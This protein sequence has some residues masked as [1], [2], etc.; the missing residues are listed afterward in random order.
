MP[1]E[2]LTLSDCPLLGDAPDLIE[3]FNAVARALQMAQQNLP[4]LL[5]ASPNLV[6]EGRRLR[7]RMVRPRYQV[8]CLGTNQSDKSLALNNVLDAKVVPEGPGAAR[9][10]TVTRLQSSQP[11]TAPALVLRFSSQERYHY[12][13]NELARRVGLLEPENLTEDELLHELQARAEDRPQAWESPAHSEDL[14]TL[15][16]LVRSAQAFGASVFREPPFEDASTSFTGRADFL[17]PNHNDTALNKYTLVEEVVVRYPTQAIPAELDMI[18]LPGPG[19]R[20]SLDSLVAN[21]LLPQCDGVLVFLTPATVMDG[22]ADALFAEL[23]QG[24][25][26]KQVGNVWL[27]VTNFDGLPRSQ[28]FGDEHGETLFDALAE[29]RQRHQL[30]PG[31]LVLLSNVL[32]ATGARLTHEGRTRLDPSKVFPRIG[33]APDDPIPPR[34]SQYR[35]IGRAFQDLVRDGGIGRL[36]SVIGT[37]L[38]AALAAELRRDVR[39]QIGALGRELHR[40]VDSQQKL[41]TH[42]APLRPLIEECQRCVHQ[43]LTQLKG[44][45]DFIDTWARQL[46]NRLRAHFEQDFPTTARNDELTIDRVAQLFPQHALSLQNCLQKVFKHRI[47]PGLYEHI[48]DTLPK[49]DIPLDG[50]TSPSLAWRGY[51]EGDKESAEF[52]QNPTF[53]RFD[54]PDLFRRPEP[55]RSTAGRAQA[56]APRQEVSRLN[57]HHYRTVMEEKIRAVTHQV[58]HVVRLFLRRR[59]DA[60]D[61][62]LSELMANDRVGQTKL[63]PSQYEAVLVELRSVC[64]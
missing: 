49:T 32:Y 5:E 14:A 29:L 39:T 61:R 1:L 52:W 6:E 40:Q 33:V 22:T 57:G 26:G 51:I 9:A 30:L 4:D 42:G 63:A 24:S 59:L 2:E 13:R 27:V 19:S 47:L 16:K 21:Y 55:H 36:R 60:M 15:V 50:Y 28:L 23:E 12:L 62:E 20:G 54:A 11:G 45:T 37:Q 56:E 48:A 8:G 10:A 34:L 17:A 31:N 64:P 41:D 44:R 46:Q 7:T 3:Q 25:A 38:K 35:D 58:M 43:L 18:D 53:P